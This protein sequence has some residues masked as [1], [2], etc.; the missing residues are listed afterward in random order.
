MLFTRIAIAPG[1]LVLVQGASGGLSTALITLAA[2][3]RARVWVTGRSEAKR[4]FAAALGA[5]ATFEPGA[6][7]PERVRYVMDSVGTATWNHSLKCLAPG[8]TLVVPGGTSGYQVQLD[9][10][11]IFA[12]QLTIAG[13]SMGSAAELAA[14]AEFCAAHDIHPPIS[15]ILPLADARQGFDDMHAGRTEGKIVLVP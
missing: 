11:L 3:A 14:L 1:D 10:S 15:A 13:T 4:K 2:A 12:R 7:L 8:G 6:R 9:I 5:E